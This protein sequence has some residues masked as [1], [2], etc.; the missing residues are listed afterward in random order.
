MGAIWEIS[1]PTLNFAVDLKLLYKKIK[2]LKKIQ[3]IKNI[4]YISQTG[5]TSKYFANVAEFEVNVYKQ[6]YIEGPPVIFNR[7]YAKQLVYECALPKQ[8]SNMALKP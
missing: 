6:L 4:K 5:Y 8:V 1:V 2:T 7:P 3:F